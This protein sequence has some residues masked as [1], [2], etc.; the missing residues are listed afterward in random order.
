MAKRNRGG[1][2]VLRQPIPEAVQAHTVKKFF[3]EH[4]KMEGLPDGA[5]MLAVL[6]TSPIAPNYRDIADSLKAINRKDAL[7]VVL[8][9]FDEVQLFDRQQMRDAGWLWVGA[10][11]Q[12]ESDGEYWDELEEISK[13][14]GERLGLDAED[15]SPQVIGA[16]LSAYRLKL[17]HDMQVMTKIWQQACTVHEDLKKWTVPVKEAN[18]WQRMWLRW[19]LWWKGVRGD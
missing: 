13:A 10:P 18:A 6:N 19:Q 12:E 1:R 15:V 16:L 5:F 4:V 8:S 3:A 9:D 14:V 17:R 7:V 11:R 2:Q